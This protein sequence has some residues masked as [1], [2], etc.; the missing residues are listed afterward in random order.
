MYADNFK[1]VFRFS[2]GDKA[3][4]NILK[5]DMFFQHTLMLFLKGKIALFFIGAI[6]MISE[7]ESSSVSTPAV[8]L[9]KMTTVSLVL[10]ISM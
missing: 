4:G 7:N 5:Q 1:L 6:S 10:P 8:L 9:Q 2:F 3:P